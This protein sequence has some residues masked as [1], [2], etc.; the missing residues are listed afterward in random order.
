VLLSFVAREVFD[1]NR[2]DRAIAT[3]TAAT[4]LERAVVEYVQ[5]Q[6]SLGWLA[7][8]SSLGRDVAS[9]GLRRASSAMRPRL[10]YPL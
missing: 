9:G 1:V 4:S 3:R 10:P 6:E 5:P 7:S 8:R 2:S